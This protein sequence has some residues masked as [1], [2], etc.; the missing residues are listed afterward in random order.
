MKIRQDDFVLPYKDKHTIENQINSGL[1]FIS[2]V[3]SYKS[4]DPGSDNRC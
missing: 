2:G 1:I 3:L 4:L